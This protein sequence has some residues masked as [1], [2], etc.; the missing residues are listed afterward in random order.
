VH[1]GT[2]RYE[3]SPEHIARQGGTLDP[4]MTG[5]GAW[6]WRLRQAGR[7]SMPSS[8]RMSPRYG[9]P[10]GHSADGQRRPVSLF[11]DDERSPDATGPEVESVRRLGP[12]CFS[13]RCF[14]QE[15]CAGTARARAEKSRSNGGEWNVG[16]WGQGYGTC[17][18]FD[19]PGPW[20]PNGAWSTKRP[21]L[22]PPHLA[23]QPPPYPGVTFVEFF[24]GITD[25]PIDAH[26]AL[27]ALVG[28]G[29]WGG[30]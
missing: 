21:L 12:P 1:G 24:S 6:P 2:K 17:A 7:P 4:S 5:F 30:G 19:R 20:E 29:S 3:Q 15:L 28:R 11:A 10:L 16:S 14:C 26:P 18:A 8:P 23:T 13:S 9:R 25:V 27:R 22:S